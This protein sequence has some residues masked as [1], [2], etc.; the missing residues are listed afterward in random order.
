MNMAIN[1]EQIEYS[2]GKLV[3]DL[4]GQVGVCAETLDGSQRSQIN[5]D[6]VF[7]TAS[8]IK[9]Y[10]LFTLLKKVQT[11]HLSLDDRIDYEDSNRKPGSGVLSHLSAGLRPTLKDLATL[12]MMISDNTAL[13]MLTSFLGLDTIN[14]E[15][16]HL[17]LE[18]TRMGDW[19]NFET[20]YADTLSF[21]VSTPDEFVSFLLRMR[22]GKLL[23][24]KLKVIF[25]GIFRIQK[26]IEPL[27]KFLPASPW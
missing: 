23:P 14:R 13:V 2:I 18:K 6:D 21:G 4:S 10:V 25:W 24:K 27:R 9:M 26:Y 8:S 17:G 20:N 15:I 22:K 5:S 7:P 19:S 3:N 12:M 16:S 1:F 11:K